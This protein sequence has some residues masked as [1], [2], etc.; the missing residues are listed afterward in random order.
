MVDGAGA[1]REQGPGL[2]DAPGGNRAGREQ[3]ADEVLELLRAVPDPVPA[4][5]NRQVVAGGLAHGRGQDAPR[6]PGEVAPDRHP[7]QQ[8]GPQRQGHGRVG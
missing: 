8:L 6:G 1:V 3:V 2:G 7:H 4:D 5:R